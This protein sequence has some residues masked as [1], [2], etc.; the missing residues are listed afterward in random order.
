[1]ALDFETADREP[2]SAC[3]VA[4]VV[5]ECGEIVE[6]FH[7]LIRPP[8]REFVFSYVHGIEWRHVRDQPSF[9]ELWPALAERLGRGRFVAAHNAR[10]DRGVLACCCHNAGL[11]P[12]AHAFACTME[13][14]RRTWGIYPTRLPDVCAR[15]GIALKHH[16]PVSDAE[17]CAR[18]VL[19]ATI[20]RA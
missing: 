9:G 5:V 14:A 19:A 18:I 3:A 6:R 4:V 7:S 1:V 2:D 15:L 17:A 12:P 13:L 11:P 16:D 8:R 10:F 20:S